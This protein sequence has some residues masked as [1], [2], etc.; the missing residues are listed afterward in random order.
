[1]K[2]T[3]RNFFK[4]AGV[5][6]LAGVAGSAALSPA[7][8]AAPKRER[9][10]I[11]GAYLVT[12]DP[13]L[14]ELRGDILI[15]G[16]RI[17]SVG[18]TA[19]ASGAD[20]VD[21]RDTIALPGFIDT[22]RHTWQ[23]AVRHIGS[24]WTLF[25][26]LTT[27]FNRFGM[28]F[29]PQDVYAGNLIGRLAALESGITT[30]VDWSHVMNTPEHADA[31]VQA[32]RDAG[33]RSVFAMGWPQTPEPFKWV[34]KSTLE[35]PADI[36]RVRKQHF[37]GNSGLV[38]LQMAA[39]GP[40]FAA[41]EQVAKDLAT[42]RE[43][44]IMTTI[45]DGDGG[46]AL[47]LSEARLA[48]PDIVYVHLQN[49]KDDALKAVR[50]SGGKVSVSVVNEEWRTP[51]RGANAATVRLLRHGILPSLSA[52]TE[53]TSS[54]D[55]FSNMRGALQS[56][57]Y[58]ASN[59]PGTPAP[60]NPREW[61]PASV[62]STRKVLEMATVG[63]AAPAGLE[64]RVGML[65]PGMQ[66]DIVLLRS[67]HLN[68]FPVND[69]IGAIVVA[70]DTGSVDAVFVAGK[71]VKFNGRLVNTALVNRARKLAAESRDYVFARAGIT[72]P[73]GLKART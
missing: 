29:R 21:A 59:D 53:I 22:H 14:G 8:A 2:V 37:P 41:M 17:V 26:Y 34:Q 13:K 28:H 24:D 40:G 31:A 12:L 69:A 43:L 73:E 71:A 27:A 46:G 54:G 25:Q 62:V 44:D 20:V 64:G 7:H 66:A 9:V 23:S 10:L 11:R 1:M 42:A 70:A 36:R 19:P 5:A 47:A 72:L 60:A 68:Y 32:L 3:R 38:T 30:L 56:A 51:W 52:D 58:G 48:G 50:D 6:G 61:N 39:R 67:N 15:D 57:R 35:L 49:A 45:H 65:S 55:M 33:A 4:S 63:G 16:G 18:G